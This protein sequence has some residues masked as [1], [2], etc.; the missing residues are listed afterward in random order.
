LFPQSR[1]L[2]NI[3]NQLR[4]VQELPFVKEVICDFNVSSNSLF[5]LAALCNSTIRISNNVLLPSSNP[6]LFVVALLKATSTMSTGDYLSSTSQFAHSIPSS[7][8]HIQ[9]FPSSFFPVLMSALSYLIYLCSMSCFPPSIPIFHCRNLH[10]R[11]PQN[12]TDCQ[13]ISQFPHFFQF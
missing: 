2:T 10:Q 9:T 3:Y 5:S 7:F 1:L 6:R 8:P 4:N 13:L 12:S 11:H